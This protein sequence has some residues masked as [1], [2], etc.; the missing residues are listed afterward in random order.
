M[1]VVELRDGFGFAFEALPALRAFGE[2]LRE[3]FDG[4]GALEPS[5]F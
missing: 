5:V 4:N 2:M 1:R 3:H